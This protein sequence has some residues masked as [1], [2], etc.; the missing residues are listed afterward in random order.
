[1]K[2]KPRVE[3]ALTEQV[4]NAVERE[5]KALARQVPATHLQGPPER[6]GDRS[7]EDDGGSA[8]D[9]R[10]PDRLL[11]PA[12]VRAKVRLS[13]PTIFRLRRKGTFPAPVVLGERRIA[14]RESEIDAWLATRPH[15]V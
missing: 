2:R 1:V 6:H 9:C 13:E 14:W 10:Q 3:D 5:R 12:E 7:G 11:F 4:R 15:A 8:G